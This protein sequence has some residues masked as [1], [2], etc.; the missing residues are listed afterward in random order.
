MSPRTQRLLAEGA[1]FVIWA[2]IIGVM[3]WLIGQ[4]S[5]RVPFEALLGG[6]GALSAF[7][8]LS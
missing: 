4:P 1:W 7:R 2:V 8:L 6:L 5:S 3:A